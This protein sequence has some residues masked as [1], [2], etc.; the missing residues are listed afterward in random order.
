MTLDEILDDVFHGCAFAAFV[1]EARRRQAW[2]ESEQVRVRAFDYYEQTVAA[3]NARRGG[4]CSR[5]ARIPPRRLL[6]D[7]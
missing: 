4:S 2:P 5:P 6:R 3:K 1:E 7:G